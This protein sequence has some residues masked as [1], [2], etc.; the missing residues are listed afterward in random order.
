MEKEPL[1]L[2]QVTVA[3]ANYVHCVRLK[4]LKR[5]DV[6]CEN[7]IAYLNVEILPC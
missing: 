4:H 3:V 5:K 1:L 6:L 7:I 2:F